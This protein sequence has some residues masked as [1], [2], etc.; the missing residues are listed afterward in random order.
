MSVVVTLP[1]RLASTDSIDANR[2]AA[3]GFAKAL[4][5]ERGGSVILTPEGVR[6]P[7][8]AEQEAIR[9]GVVRRGSRRG[10]AAL[11]VQMRLALAELDAAATSRWLERTWSESIGPGVDLILGFHHRRHRAARRLARRAGVPF[12]ARVEAVETIEDRVWGVR[13]M[14]W[15]AVALR[16]EAR[17][18]SMADVVASVSPAVDG[19]LDAIGIDEGRRVVV[20]NGVDVERF[21]PAPRDDELVQR[22]RLHG[23]FI[24][25]WVGGFRP[26]HGL[27]SIPAIAAAARHL[28]PVVTFV[29]VGTG[30]VFDDVRSATAGL[31]NV[32]LTGPASRDEVVRWI[33]TS[34]ACVLLAGDGVFHYSP[35]KLLEYQSSGRPVVATADADPG[36][37][38]RDGIDGLRVPAPSAVPAAIA[39]LAADRS[40]VA[41]FGAAARARV[42]ADASWAARA[43]ELLRAVE[44]R[45]HAM[46]VGEDRR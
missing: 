29:L 27:A 39:A 17:E 6:T 22:H 45:G 15:D 35:L 32:V 7:N 9:T 37:W 19:Q 1:S 31:D 11:P 26:F 24:V 42:I 34:D 20:P 3:A 16:D 38:I 44:D 13:R 28:A 14:G 21:A 2:I 18:L 8:A 5:D 10:A 40:M 30:P 41:R 33:R 46:A 36:R 12:V 25:C 23:R 43:S 4:G